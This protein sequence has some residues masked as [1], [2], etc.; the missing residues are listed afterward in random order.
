MGWSVWRWH[1]TSRQASAARTSMVRRRARLQ[2][3]FRGL[4][5]WR[6]LRNDADNGLAALCRARFYRIRANAHVPTEHGALINRQL[7]RAKITFQPCRL[8]ELDAIGGGQ[9]SLHFALDGDGAAL[10]I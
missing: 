5:L 3:S 1:G 9:V 7:G 10:H 4:G 2:I 6:A 8:F